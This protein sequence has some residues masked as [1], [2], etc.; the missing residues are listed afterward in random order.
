MV[1]SPLSACLVH[2]ACL[3]PRLHC[4]PPA[5]ALPLWLQSRSAQTV[6]PG[7]L[8][9]RWVLFAIRPA[10]TACLA[11]LCMPTFP[12]IVVSLFCVAACRDVNPCVLTRALSC[13]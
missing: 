2:C 5:S 3:A 4:S 13:A 8:L 1:A 7:P 6:P 12:R 9:Q 10:S 11:M